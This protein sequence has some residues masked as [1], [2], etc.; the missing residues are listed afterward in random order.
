MQKK[1][2]L[3]IFLI[4][5]FALFGQL[6]YSQPNTLYYMDGIHQSSQLNPAYQNPCNGFVALPIVSDMNFMMANTGFDYNDFIHYGTGLQKDSLVMDFNNLKNKLG[7]SNYFLMN[8]D[9]PLLGFGFW[10]KNTYVTFS[11]YNKTRMRFAYPEDLIKL[12]DG[13]GNY[14]GESNPINIDGFGPFVMN[15]NEIALGLSKQITHR[16]T[17]GGRLKLLLGNVAMESRKSD[18]KLYTNETDYSMRLETD[19]QVNASAPLTYEYDGDGNISSVE[20]DDSQLSS[21]AFSTKNMGLGLDLGATYQFN[22]RIKLYAS[23]TDLGFIG[24][25]NSTKNLTQSGTFEFSGF[26]LDSVWTESDYDEAEALA[27]SLADFFT[28]SDSDTKFTTWLPTNI[29]LGGT[30]ELIPEINFGFLSKTFFYDRK[31]HQAF[32][33][34]ANFNP[35]KK[36]QASLSYSIM[37]RDYKNIG[38]GVR[39]AGFYFV[40]DYLNSFFWPK[41]SKS[42]GF[43]FGFNMNFGCGKRDNYSMIKNKKPKKDIDFM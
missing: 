42:V 4:L 33:L 9:I 20:F 23:I 34:S 31:I 40:T 30:Y 21:S 5:C 18:V 15:Y 37:N 43:H 38:L 36:V 1:R 3:Y 22:D 17:I 35:A 2:T 10:A 25:K 11:I 41:N 12:V 14:L 26:N 8:M 39:L 28:F 29:Y 16:L 7:K 24:W 27:D 6:S 19:F 32:T 13:N